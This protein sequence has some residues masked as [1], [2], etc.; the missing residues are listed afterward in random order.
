MK[1]ILVISLMLNFWFSKSVI[2]LEQFRHATQLQLTGV[3]DTCQIYEERN[4]TKVYLC[5][6]DKK[7]RTSPVWDLV[8]G[9]GFF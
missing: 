9:I 2:D 3:G 1:I 7:N 8:Y 4:K 6:E 5:L